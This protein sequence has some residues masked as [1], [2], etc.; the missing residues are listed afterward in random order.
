MAFNISKFLYKNRNNYNFCLI[1]NFYPTEIFAALFA[2]YFL[3]KKIILDFEDDYLLLTKNIF[4]KLY[5]SIVRNIPDEVI[6][7]NRNMINYFIHKKT[8]IFNGFI[9]MS[10]MKNMKIDLK[11]GS[12]FLYSGS[13]DE[14][15]GV[16]LIP[17]IV[18][19]LKKILKDFKIYISGSGILEKKI[20]TWD[21]KEV[22]FLGFLNENDY[23]K[24]IEISNFCLVLQKPDNKFSTGSFPSKVEYYSKYKKPIFYID[25]NLK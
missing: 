2:K 4:Y 25:N 13:L 1:Y 24:I 19:S 6:C 16:D 11:E 12:I 15:R 3:N 21:I 7:I 8:Y 10:Y 22:V 5:F 17:E 18:R 9:D 20:K 23:L 14:I